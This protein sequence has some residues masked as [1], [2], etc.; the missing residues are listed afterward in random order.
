M[1]SNPVFS[2]NAF[3]YN[4]GENLILEKYGRFP[5]IKEFRDLLVNPIL[6]SDLV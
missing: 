2:K 4:L 3:M 5:R 1:V 6:P